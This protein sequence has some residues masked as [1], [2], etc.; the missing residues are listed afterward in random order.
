MAAALVVSL[1]HFIICLL[2]DFT[3][4]INIVKYNDRITTVVFSK[5]ICRAVEN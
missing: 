5:W 4:Q 1:Q 2:I 3:V